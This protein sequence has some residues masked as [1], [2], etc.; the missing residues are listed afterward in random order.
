MMSTL[1]P[2]RKRGRPTTRE[3]ALEYDRDLEKGVRQIK[4]SAWL[5]QDIRHPE[6]KSG[7]VYDTRSYKKHGELVTV[8]NVTFQDAPGG[9][10][11]YEM[12]EDALMEM[13]EVEIPLKI[14]V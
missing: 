12:E 6:H 11:D 9:P 10:K 4:P 2:V 14:C 7:M 1:A 8:W 13:E 5:Q 3:K